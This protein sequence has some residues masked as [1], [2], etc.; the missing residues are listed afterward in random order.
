M[1]KRST[2]SDVRSGRTALDLPPEDDAGIVQWLRGKIEDLLGTVA[3]VTNRDH[4]DVSRHFSVAHE[5]VCTP[6]QRC[7]RPAIDVYN[8]LIGIIGAMQC[9]PTK[10]NLILAAARLQDVVQCWDCLE[11]FRAQY[12]DS[13]TGD[14]MPLE[15]VAVLVWAQYDAIR[16]P[17][18]V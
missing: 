16:T 7:P 2:R 11:G 1:S 9:V 15:E 13:L 4:A 17:V 10:G 3:D 6:H 8:V 18:E 5:L 14:P 12:P